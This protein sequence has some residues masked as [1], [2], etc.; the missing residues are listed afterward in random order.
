VL[1]H[2][3]HLGERAQNDFLDHPS[4]EPVVSVGD[5]DGSHSLGEQ[6]FQL[7]GDEEKIRV[8]EGFVRL[9]CGSRCQV[10]DHF[11]QQGG[12]SLGQV[13]VESEGDSVRPRRCVRGSENDFEGQ[14][15]VNFV[16][17]RADPAGVASE[18]IANG[19][20]GDLFLAPDRLPAL[21]ELFSDVARVLEEAICTF[22]S[23]TRPTEDR[24]VV[25]AGGEGLLG[26]LEEVEGGETSSR[27]VAIFLRRG[28]EGIPTTQLLIDEALEGGKA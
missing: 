16:D 8:V 17:G 15:F 21:A 12:S 9:G 6:S 24:N 14:V 7:L 11:Q 28:V 2:P 13:L 4:Y 27:S 20:R 1:T 3:Q 25:A 23:S 22:S 18:V 5:G 10:S 26:E 19:L